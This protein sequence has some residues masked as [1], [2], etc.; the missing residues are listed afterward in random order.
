M[1]ASLTIIS[2]DQL[3]DAGVLVFSKNCVSRCKR[4]YD[5]E[6]RVSF[7]VYYDGTFVTR[8]TTGYNGEG[9]VRFGVY[10]DEAF[11]TRCTTGYDGEGKV[12]PKVWMII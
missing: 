7:G 10:Y 3:S 1:Q 6:G 12:V 8:C 2:Y 4:G 5:G 11:V 9:R